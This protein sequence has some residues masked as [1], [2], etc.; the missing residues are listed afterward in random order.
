MSSSCN[1]RTH[2]D[3]VRIVHWP[4]IPRMYTPMYT[5]CSELGYTYCSRD[6]VTVKTDVQITL[7][8][9]QIFNFSRYSYSHVHTH[10]GSNTAIFDEGTPHTVPILRQRSLYRIHIHL[11]CSNFVKSKNCENKG[12]ITHFEMLQ[13]IHCMKLRAPGINNEIF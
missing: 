8:A 7:H 11:A 9:L 1:L 4:R 12:L 6:D 13:D 2:H 10:L 3:V 5:C